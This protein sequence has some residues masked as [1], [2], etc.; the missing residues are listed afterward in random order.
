MTCLGVEEKL[1]DVA[2][3]DLVIAADGAHP[4][5]ALDF[6]QCT[7]LDEFISRLGP[8]VE[9]ESWTQERT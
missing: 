7:G 2:V 8:V 5:L 9:L 1:D 6:V 4:A 3:A